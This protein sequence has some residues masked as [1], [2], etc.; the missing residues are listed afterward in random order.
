V[1]DL[2][3]AEDHLL[4][5][6]VLAPMQGDEAAEAQASLQMAWV[7]LKGGYPFQARPHLDRAL[8]L[9][10]WLGEERIGL[11]RVIAWCAY[12]EGNYRLAFDVQRQVVAEVG[13]RSSGPHQ[14]GAF[15][16]VFRQALEEGQR[17]PVPGEEGYR[18][19]LEG[20]A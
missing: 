6:L 14:D 11:Q 7:L 20:G 1:Q 16:E 10:R 4:E 18:G 5:V 12:E 8:A 3:A 15:L 19:D 17:L 2:E 9:D 13:A